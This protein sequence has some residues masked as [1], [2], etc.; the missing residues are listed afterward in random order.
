MNLGVGLVADR[1]PSDKPDPPRRDIDWLWNT[2]TVSGPSQTVAR[3]RDIARGTNA[4]PWR[5]DLDYEEARL[6]APMAS[7]GNEARLLARALREVIA[8]RQERVSSHWAGPGRCPFDL[9]RLVPVP[10]EILA[11]GSGDP[12]SLRWLQEN[13]GTAKPLRHVTILDR[14]EDKRLRRSA[15]FSVRFQSADWTPGKRSFGSGG[16]GASSCSTCGRTTA[17]SEVAERAGG[18][19]S[20]G[21]GDRLWDDWDTPPR[22]PSSP[23]LHL[24]GFE[25]TLDLLLDLVERQ[26]IDLGRI[27]VLQLAEQFVSAMDRLVDHVPLERRADW[28]VTASRLVLLWSRLC[29]PASPEAK[30]DAERETRRTIDRLAEVQFTRAAAAWLERQ[31]QLGRDVFRRGMGLSPR[32]SS[33]MD[34]MEACL[35]L[36]IREEEQFTFDPQAVAVFLVTSLPFKVSDLIETIRSRLL[37]QDRALPFE[38]FIPSAKSSPPAQNEAAMAVGHTFTAALELARLGEATISQHADFATMFISRQF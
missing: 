35:T 5:V 30:A 7:A 33:Y 34:L 38:S 12:M 37:V 1:P 36:L 13:W 18:E 32:V 28:L 3:F 22:I 20:R 6:L 26:R 9:Y 10:A 16:S 25:G 4:A 17:M 31:P 24:E 15:R 8:A 11:L 21:S 29:F 27:S 2:V 14:L 23:E 19:D